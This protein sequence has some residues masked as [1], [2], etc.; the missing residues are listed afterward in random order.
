MNMVV[1]VGYWRGCWICW[2]RSRERQ[3]ASRTSCASLR[4]RYLWLSTTTCTHHRTTSS[5]DCRIQVKKGC[6]SLC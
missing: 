6:I 2:G 3:L 1:V 4:P 5:E